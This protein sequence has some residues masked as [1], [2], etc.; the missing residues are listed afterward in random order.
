MFSDGAATSMRD[1]A[2][3][4]DVVEWGWLAAGVP[5]MLIARW[6][7]PPEARERLLAEFH[8]R[9]RAGEPIGR[10]LGG[11]AAADPLDSRDGRARPLG[12]LD[13]A[14]RGRYGDGARAADGDWDRRRR[15]APAAAADPERNPDLAQFRRRSLPRRCRARVEPRVEGPADHA[16]PPHRGDNRRR[17]DR[18]PMMGMERDTRRENRAPPQR[19]SRLVIVM[20]TEDARRIPVVHRRVPFTVAQFRF[21]QRYDSSAVNRTS[22]RWHWKLGAGDWKLEPVRYRSACRES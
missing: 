1:S 13:A 12:R 18:A 11:S 9:L 19:V 6:S 2:A 4:A 3:A 7:A 5:S 10:R 14:R 15:L 22:S 8:R 20:L 21:A 16:F 17:R